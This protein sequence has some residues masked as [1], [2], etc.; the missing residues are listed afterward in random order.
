VSGRSGRGTF[1]E[2]LGPSQLARF[3]A[4]TLPHLDAAYMLARYLMGNDHDAEDVVQEAFLR[5]LRY[6][7]GYHGG[8]ARA[9]LLAIVRNT[10]RSSQRRERDH[11][12]VVEFDETL[13]SEAIEDEHPEAEVLRAADRE[14]VRRA[15][16]QLPLEFREVIVLRE[17][18]G[19]SYRE[20]GEISGIP[21][22]TVMS[23]LA[24]A[25]QRLERMLGGEKGP[26]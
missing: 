18:Q 14:R 19:L 16:D 7:D 6:F 17:L 22:G 4:A 23:R 25:R 2:P 15:L 10:T 5:A 24:R 1:E 8:N 11:G 26:A 20:I 3:E 9:W 12:P 21:V 13:H